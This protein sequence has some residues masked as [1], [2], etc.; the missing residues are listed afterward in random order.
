MSVLGVVRIHSAQSPDDLQE[1]TQ[2]SRG[3]LTSWQC[4]AR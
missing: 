2:R 4:L 3:Q 1:E